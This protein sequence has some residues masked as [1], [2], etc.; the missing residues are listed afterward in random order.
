LY[1]GQLYALPNTAELLQLKV[2]AV[3]AS[4]FAAKRPVGKNTIST[5]GKRIATMLRLENPDGYTGHCWRRTATTLC[6]E[7][8]LSIPQMKAVTGHRSDTVLQGYID[9]SILMK[10]KAADAISTS[11]PNPAPV[12]VNAQ[13]AA[14]SQA[15]PSVITINFIN[16]TL[17]AQENAPL[18]NFAGASFSF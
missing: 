13:A 12:V 18:V 8:G 4:H 15:M 6:A 10:R 5:Y 17:T 9:N 3:V 11:R 1:S 16:S 2:Y 7:A 14:G